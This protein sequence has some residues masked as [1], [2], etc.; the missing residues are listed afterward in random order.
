VYPDAIKVGNMLNKREQL[1]EMVTP[2]DLDVVAAC[3]DC[4]L[5]ED[6]LIAHRV[7][8]SVALELTIDI[9]LP[10]RGLDTRFLPLE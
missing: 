1:A 6:F 7:F 10:L 9:E 3:G 8:E 4:G 2:G 5:A